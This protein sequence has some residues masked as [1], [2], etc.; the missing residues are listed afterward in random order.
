MSVIDLSSSFLLIGRDVINKLLSTIAESLVGV[1][2]AGVDTDKHVLR[3][4]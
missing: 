1:V 2:G 4:K 3:I